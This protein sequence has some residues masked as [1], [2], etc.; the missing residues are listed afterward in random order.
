MLVSPCAETVYKPFLWGTKSD[1]CGRK[2][3]S[4]WSIYYTN[5]WTYNKTAHL[6]TTSF[7]NFQQQ[8]KAAAACSRQLLAGGGATQTGGGAGG[9][10]SRM[11]RLALKSRP[12]SSFFSLPKVTLYCCFIKVL[13]KETSHTHAFFF[14]MNG[15][16]AVCGGVRAAVINYACYA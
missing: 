3:N 7:N 13:P 16:L 4:I 14:I 2:C 12:R 8:R 1:S 5:N 15:R 6:S 9:T 10:L 11:K